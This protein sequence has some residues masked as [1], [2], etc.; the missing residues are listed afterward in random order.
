MAT[1]VT[2]N[3]PGR[4]AVPCEHV[5]R[6]I[7]Y[8]VLFPKET[9][10]ALHDYNYK[11]DDI[12]LTTYPK[13]GEWKEYLGA[14]HYSDVIMSAIVSLIASVLT[15]YSAVCSGADQRK[16]QSSVLLAFVRGIQWWA[17][18][19]PRKGSV[20]RKMFPFNDIIMTSS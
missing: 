16:H 14:I 12:I 13:C 7:V 19:S 2:K 18:N 8:N 4:H 11:P 20:A 15:V 17:V 9:L 6:G 1:T 10:E 5:Y 3:R